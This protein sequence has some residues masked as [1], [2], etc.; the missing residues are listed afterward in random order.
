VVSF[1]LPWN[2]VR[3]EQ[4]IGRV[5][6]IGQTRS[7]HAT[8][9][10]ARHTAETGVLSRLA[11]RTLNAQRAF[12]GDILR[13]AAPPPALSMARALI[14]GSDDESRVSAGVTLRSSETWR[15]S[16]RAVASQTVARRTLAR[17][18]RPPPHQVA[19]RCGRSPVGPHASTL[20]VRRAL[21]SLID[22]TA[23]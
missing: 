19:G 9:L 14:S 2:P 11:A 21:N 5:D 15:R 13:D 12:G 17:Q 22:G 23:R 10:I 8:L 6:R 7:A 20:V 1:E 18:W 4:R 16:A 3:L